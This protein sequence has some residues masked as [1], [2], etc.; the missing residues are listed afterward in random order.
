MTASRADVIAAVRDA[1]IIADPDGLRDDV[2]LTD[3]GIDSLG[4]FNIILLLQEKYEIEI[5][6]ADIDALDSIPAIVDYLN[7]RL[8]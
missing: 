6:D 1:D 8:A 7:R 2:P 3:Q 4:L 5:P